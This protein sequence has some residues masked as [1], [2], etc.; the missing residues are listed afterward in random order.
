MQLYLENESG[1]ILD[2]D[3]EDIARNVNNKVL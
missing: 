3:A 2:F 1:I